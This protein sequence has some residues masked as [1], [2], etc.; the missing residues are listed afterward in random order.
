MP[1][2]EED[3]VLCGGIAPGEREA[4]RADLDRLPLDDVE[5]ICDACLMAFW[6]NLVS[7]DED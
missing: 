5:L 6:R 1:R 7:D 4:F 3:C 2:D